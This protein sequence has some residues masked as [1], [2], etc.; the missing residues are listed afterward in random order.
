MYSAEAD[1]MEMVDLFDI[2]TL[3]AATGN[4]DESNKLGEGGFG[5]VYKVLFEEAC[6]GNFWIEKMLIKRVLH[7][8]GLFRVF[9]P[10][11][12]KR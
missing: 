8:F 12:A 5:K 1:D 2:S 3:R 4:F 11:T 9:S 7:L 6:Q 10:T